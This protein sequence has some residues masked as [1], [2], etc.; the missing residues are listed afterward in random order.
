MP[1]SI[2]ESPV[3]LTEEALRSLKRNTDENSK[4]LSSKMSS[5]VSESGYQ[6]PNLG[7]SMRT[8]LNTGVL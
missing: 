4:S 1:P 6:R 3:P 8:T 2:S 5:D 7:R